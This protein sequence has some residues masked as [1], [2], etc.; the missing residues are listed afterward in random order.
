MLQRFTENFESS[1]DSLNKNY[2]SELIIKHP[3]SNNTEDERKAMERIEE[4]NSTSSSSSEEDYI[5]AYACGSQSAETEDFQHS[6]F[7][8][9]R[10]AGYDESMQKK[11]ITIQENKYLDRGQIEKENGTQNVID[12]KIDYSDI[13]TEKLSPTFYQ[14]KIAGCNQSVKMSD[15][16]HQDTSKYYNRGRELE[17][18]RRKESMI[19]VKIDYSDNPINDEFMK[20]SEQQVESKNERRNGAYRNYIKYKIIQ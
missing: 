2:T 20:L 15:T 3:G 7:L 16:K 12:I 5:K 6:T 10:M 1:Q 17:E 13:P 18:E 19:D 11:E 14:S 4:E 9:S 8:N